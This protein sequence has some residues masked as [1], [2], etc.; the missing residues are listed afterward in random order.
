MHLYLSLMTDR[1]VAWLSNQQY[2]PTIRVARSTVS[3]SSSVVR[4]GSEA[5]ICQGWTSYIKALL[6][7]AILFLLS[8]RGESAMLRAM[9][10]LYHIVY[11]HD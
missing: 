6:L 4:N 7:H 3:V 1:S 11:D 8:L 9:R 10:Y 2:C 5:Q